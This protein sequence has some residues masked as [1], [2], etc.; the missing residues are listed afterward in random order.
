MGSV[1][2]AVPP[3]CTLTWWGFTTRADSVG[4]EEGLLSSQKNKKQK[5]PCFF[6]YQQ[7]VCPLKQQG[8]RTDLC[9]D[10][11]EQPRQL[12]FTGPSAAIL[13]SRWLCAFMVDLRGRTGFTGVA[14]GA[15]LCT[16]AYVKH[17]A[18]GKQLR[19][20]SSKYWEK[21]WKR[22]KGSRP[23]ET[24]KTFHSGRGGLRLALVARREFPGRVCFLTSFK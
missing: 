2:S 3:T 11:I 7:Q 14:A 24:Q 21:E 15:A 13:P 6:H 16:T 18:F 9:V 23:L 10:E 19:Q 12:T 8:Q 5:R 22:G 1:L 20:S 17:A 4:R